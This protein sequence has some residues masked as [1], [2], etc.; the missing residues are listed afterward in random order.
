[1]NPLILV[2]D[3]DDS[4]RDSICEY[5]TLS[6]FTADAAPDA[7]TALRLLSEKNYDVV[8]TD[9]IMSGMDGLKLTAHIKAAHD[10]SV[11]IITGYTRDY[12]YETAVKKGADDFVFKPF[13]LEE[14]LLRLKRVLRERRIAQ[15]RNEMLKEF[16]VL[17]ITDH[18]TGLYNARHFHDQ[19][20]TEII[21][22]N[23]Y[24]RPLSLLMI[25]IDHFKRYNDTYGHLAGDRILSNMGEAIAA[26]LRTPDTAYRYGGEEFAVILPETDLESA[27]LAAKRIKNEVEGEL[28]AHGNDNDPITISIGATAYRPGETP[29]ALL[30]RADK[31]MYAA[32]NKGRDSISIL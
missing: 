12:T 32:K 7:E 18:L 9:I 23:R 4:I 14:L 5:L 17:S 10:T 31:A 6:D 13:R 20:Q 8:I 29:D 22:H 3:D 25:D 27:S 11:I 28:A 2:V 19:L 15:E 1:M 26:I 16:K 21:R 30:D 24:Q